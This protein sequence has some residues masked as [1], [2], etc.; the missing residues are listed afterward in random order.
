MFSLVL[1]EDQDVV[2][3]NGHLALSDQ[4]AEDVVHHPLECGGR[5]GEPEEHN[6]GFVQTPVRAEGG[7]LLVSFSDSDVVVPPTNVKLRE[8]LGSTKFVNELRDEREWVTVFDHHLVE[9]PKILYGS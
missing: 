5:I 1:G 6:G 9:L 8:V 4:V 3:V 2:E 7:F